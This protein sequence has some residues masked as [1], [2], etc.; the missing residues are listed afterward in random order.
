VRLRLQTLRARAMA[1]SGRRRPRPIR[2]RPRLPR[3]RALPQ[4]ALATA[5]HDCRTGTCAGQA[6]TSHA[7]QRAGCTC[8]GAGGRRRAGEEQ[9]QAN[10]HRP[11]K[12]QGD[13]RRT[14]RPGPP[15]AVALDPQP[16]PRPRWCSATP[17]ALTGSSL[18]CLA[19]LPLV[20]DKMSHLGS[21]RGFY[22]YFLRFHRLRLLPFSLI[23]PAF[24]PSD[25]SPGARSGRGHG[26][27]RWTRACK[28]SF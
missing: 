27:A 14:D 20:V 11:Q 26:G 15:R 25:R 7:T 18:L 19:L 5:P 24:C 2:P 28:R 4:H 8:E 12:I 6:P 23:G 22:F 10:A 21:V 16:A 3:R 1:R 9:A 13:G 17:P